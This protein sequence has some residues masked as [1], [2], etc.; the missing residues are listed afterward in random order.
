M[1]FDGY[2]KKICAIDAALI[3]P[4]AEKIKSINWED[5]SCSRDEP[6]LVQGKLIELPFI[7][8][9]N[10]NPSHHTEELVKLCQ[11]II[12]LV[13][14]HFPNC[15]KVRGEVATVPPG[16][17]LDFHVDPHW[18]H[19]NCHRIHIPIITNDQCFQLWERPHYREHL[20][21]GYMYEINNFV[22][23]SAENNGKEYRTHIIIDVCD[24][25]LYMDY[26]HNGGNILDWAWL[27][28]VILPNKSKPY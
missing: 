27:E 24:K 21:V 23:H 25:T 5:A 18:F 22:Y 19:A 15:I 11:P 3:A 7:L 16:K 17:A 8:V 1:K 4:I 6:P 13:H 20:E 28:P 12:D 10:T 9:N 14:K 26:V 2:T